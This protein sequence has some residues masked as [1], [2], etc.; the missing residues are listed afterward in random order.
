[1][2]HRGGYVPISYG[3]IRAAVVKSKSKDKNAT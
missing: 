3:K 1:V 2:G